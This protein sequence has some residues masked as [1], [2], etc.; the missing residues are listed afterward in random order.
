[1][2][3]R[4]LSRFVTPEVAPSP[5][6]RRAAPSA[7]L[8]AGALSGLLGLGV[9]VNGC[10]NGNDDN[11]P[12]VGNDM[13]TPAAKDLGAPASNDLS[14]SYK[15][16]VSTTPITYDQFTATCRARGGLVQTTAICAGNN[17]CKGLSYLNGTLTEHSCAG[18]NGCGPGFSCVDLPADTGRTGKDIYEKGTCAPTCHAQFTPTYDPSYYYLQVRP[19]TVTLAQ[20]QDRFLNGPTERLESII[21]F[22]TSG[23][24]P[25]GTAYHTMPAS[26]QLYSLAEI[27]RV[28]AYI[29]TLPVVTQYYGIPGWTED[30]GT[31]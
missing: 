2:N 21:G 27:D 17:S 8:L 14:A 25:D 11:P 13:A 31:P 9:A 19:D 20:A 28:I 5:R 16:V 30:G 4:V 24:N 29:R 10:G 18:M 22:G 15:I 12:P 23:L 6:R 3:R 1:M 7:S 26:Y